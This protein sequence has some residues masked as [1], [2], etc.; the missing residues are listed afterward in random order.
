MHPTQS[1]NE[2]LRYAKSRLSEKL[3]RATHVPG[4]AQS[5]GTV[6]QVTFATPVDR[7]WRPPRSPSPTPGSP[8]VSPGFWAANVPA[9]RRQ[10]I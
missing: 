10:R 2:A 7:W 5:F 3:R 1:V 4:M 8:L 6:T 9:D